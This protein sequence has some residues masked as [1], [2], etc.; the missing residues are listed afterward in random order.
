VGFDDIEMMLA[1][2]EK[3]ASATFRNIT[4]D[5]LSL[6]TA[7]RV[8]HASIDGQLRGVWS[9]EAWKESR[10]RAF[11]EAEKHLDDSSGKHRESFCFGQA[12]I[13]QGALLVPVS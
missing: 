7:Y 12:M 5:D 10:R 2:G 11:E 4:G 8:S 3:G 6:R 1:P 9:V 13:E